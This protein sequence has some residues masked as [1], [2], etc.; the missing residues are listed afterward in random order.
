MRDRPNPGERGDAPLSGLESD[1]ETDLE[2]WVRCAAC[3]AGL[4]PEKARIAIGG[5]HEHEFM[6]PAGIRFRVACF[7]SAQGTTADG[8]RSKVW[9]WFPGHAWQIA[10]CRACGA[11]VGWSF[12]ADS[13]VSFWGLVVDR[14][15]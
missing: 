14:I 10:L 3:G 9:T 12:H 6:N 15:R 7:A 4:A 2:K 5:A 8:E 13:G 1:D 11:H